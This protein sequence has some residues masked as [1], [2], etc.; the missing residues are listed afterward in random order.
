[1]RRCLFGACAVVAFSAASGCMS[2]PLV[3]P[4]PQPVADATVLE[5]PAF[6]PGGHNNYHQVFEKC[7][8]VLIDQ[9]FEIQEANRFDGRIEAL[10]RNAP[11]LLLWFKPGTPSSRERLLATLQSY[12]HRVSIVI[13]PA[14]HGDFFIEVIARRELEDLPKPARATAGAA[15]FR[16]DPSVERQFEVIDPIVFDSHWIYKGRDHLLE[17]QIIERLKS[18]L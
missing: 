10:P 7:L 5:N 17:Q 6:F 2:G 4:A 14:T 13:Q 11:G 16:A 8:S 15:V 12:R 9:G 18:C 3:E 1:M